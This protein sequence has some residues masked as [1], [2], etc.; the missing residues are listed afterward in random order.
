MIL[1]QC[2]QTPNE[3]LNSWVPLPTGGVKLALMPCLV[4]LLGIEQPVLLLA[5]WEVLKDT[6]G[7]QNFGCVSPES[8]EQNSSKRAY[9]LVRW[10][11]LESGLVICKF[12]SAKQN[13]ACCF[14]FCFP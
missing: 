10:V 11:S 4:E 3:T 13:S 9:L 12:L 14:S 7:K 2:D 5:G 6:T 8:T 1:A